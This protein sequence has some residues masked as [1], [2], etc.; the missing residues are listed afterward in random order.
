MAA[1]SIRIDN[2]SRPAGSRA[3]RVVTRET[4]L[5]EVW[6]HRDHLRSNGLLVYMAT[7]SAAPAA[8]P[9]RQ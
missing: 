9:S 2:S 4:I 1:S 8:L 6:R 7:G 3:G 5:D